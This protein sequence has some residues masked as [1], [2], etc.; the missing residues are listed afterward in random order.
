MTPIP[1]RTRLI[2][3]LLACGWT[4]TDWPKTSKYAC[5]FSPITSQVALVGPAGAM[6]ILPNDQT[7]ISQST[8]AT[9]SL[10][11]RALIE[12]GHPDQSFANPEEARDGLALAMDR[13]RTEARKQR[14]AK[15]TK[16]KA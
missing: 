7:P 14:D 3:G 11:Y 4:K 15:Q 9:D 5:Y 10:Q 6:R 13:L 2:R 16:A 1:K 8:S 12:I